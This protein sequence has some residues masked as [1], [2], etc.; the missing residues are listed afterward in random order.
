MDIAIIG[1]GAIG[2]YFGARLAHAGHTVHFLAHTE[3]DYIR[4]H[5]LRVESYLGDFSLAQ[6]LVYDDIAA[7]PPCDLVCVTTKTT[8]NEFLLP[9]LGPA[10]RPGSALLLMQNGFG[11]EPTLAALYPEARIFAGLCFIC[12]FRDGPGRV[13]HTAYGRVSLAALEPDPA[14][15]AALAQVFEGAGVEAETLGDVLTARLR[16]LVWNLPF[17]GLSVALDCTTEELGSDPAALALVR[18][19]MGE[20]VGAAAAAGIAI[21]PEFVEARVETT[22]SMGPYEPSMRLDYLARRPMEIEAMYG[23]VIRFARER[24]YEMTRAQMLAQELAFLQGR[25]GGR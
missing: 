17:N 7:L 25:Y 1:T 12:S 20:V 2:G 13:R 9:R 11:I 3:Y 23:N 19:L 8:S 15:L 18:G 21:E 14:G 24:G 16:K 22:Q 10:L 4:Q 6:P 5:G